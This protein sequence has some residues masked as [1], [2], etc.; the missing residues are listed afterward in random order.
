MKTLQLIILT[1]FAFVFT[2]FSGGGQNAT[3]QQD[4]SYSMYMFNMLEINP[5]YAGSREQISLSGIYRHQ[6]AGF[7]GAPRI[8]TFSGHAPLANKNIALG[9]SFT[10]D[11]IGPSNMNELTLD[12]AYRIPMGSGK[13]SLGLRTSIRNYNVEYSELDVNDPDDQ[14]FNY[15]NQTLWR[16]NFGA[17]VF[18]YAD[19]FYAGFSVPHIINNS[20]NENWETAGT[21]EVARESRHYLLNGGVVI[22][23][24]DKV[25]FKPSTLIKYVPNTPLQADVNASFL[26][27]EKLWI[28]ASYR[29]S[30]ASE[31]QDRAAVLG[32]VEYYFAKN[33]RAGYAYDYSLAELQDHTSGTHEIMIGYEFGMTKDR[34]LTPRRMNYF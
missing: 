20:L 13:L 15:D 21:Q 30:V 2:F 19:R 16:P 8:M 29:T 6:W 7:D 4:R 33:F 27:F 22:P 9:A 12:Y 23:L 31:Y 34:Y 24:A 28:G 3:A 32:M 17:G 5:A 18:Y 1:G 25:D 10:N 14:A 26:F 11:R